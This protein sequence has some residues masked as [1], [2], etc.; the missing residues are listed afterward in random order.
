MKITSIL[1]IYDL[2]R[3]CSYEIY[4]HKGRLEAPIFAPDGTWILVNTEGLLWKLPLDNPQLIAIDTQAANLCNN[5]HGF[6]K[7]GRILFGSHYEQ[8]GAQIYSI[9]IGGGDLKKVSKSP[10]SWWHAISP[11]AKTIAYPAVRENSQNL[12]IYKWDMIGAEIQLTDLDGH[13]DGCD[14]SADG[15]HIYW[16]CDLGGHAQ[17]WIMTQ[18]GADQ[19][20]LF[21]DEKVNW[22]PHPSPNGRDLI[23]LAYPK[24]TQG[25]PA[26]RDVEIIL[27]RTDG[28]QREAILSFVGG[29]G[30]LNVP[31]WHPEGKCFAYIRYEIQ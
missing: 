23:Y 30:S 15:S 7:D 31:P 1:E 8:K 16:N 9:S 10:R 25:H 5:D 12:Q 17:I 14:F 28:G 2:D 6:T 20:P 22:F 18:N 21:S 27:C 26:D 3:R 19:R 13:N 29:Q 11:D 24:G 4:R